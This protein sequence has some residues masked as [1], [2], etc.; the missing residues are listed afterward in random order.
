MS[1]LTPTYAS[2]AVPSQVFA[3][4]GD[5]RRAGGV[6]LFAVL[7]WAAGSQAWLLTDPYTFVL[8]HLISAVGGL[9]A[10]SR[11]QLAGTLVDRAERAEREQDLLAERAVIAERIRLAGEMHDLVS[12]QITLMVLQAGV[13][14]VGP[15]IDDGTRAAAERLQAS[16]R[17]AL[18]ELRGLID[19]LRTPDEVDTQ[20]A[21]RSLSDG[22]L[23]L[24][25]TARGAGMRID[26]QLDGVRSPQA[27]VTD[28]FVVHTALRVVQEGLTNAGR[29]APGQP[30]VIRVARRTVDAAEQLLAVTV[31][32]ARAPDS[33][34]GDPG[35]GLPVMRRRVELL[36][37]RLSVHCD[38]KSHEIRVALPVP[39]HAEDRK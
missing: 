13:L 30:I 24:V 8:I 17:Q 3:F 19:V 32:N 2:F 11:V 33:R 7:T 39:A 28:P 34:A 1:L 31:T 14:E 35:R 36:G 21:T 23:E 25:T 9:L 4:T 16:G 12:H 37:G 10:R 20:P 22:V 27:A 15:G 5:R 29:H 6:A 38:E 18:T 26:L